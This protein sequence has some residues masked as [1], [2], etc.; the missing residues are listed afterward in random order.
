MNEAAA[1]PK[2]KTE[3]TSVTMTDGRVVEFAGKRKMLKDTLIDDTKIE[4]SADKSVLQISAGAVKVRLDFRNGQTITYD[5][6]LDLAARFAGHGAEQKLGDNL[7]SKA[8]DPMSEE[9][10][11]LETEALVA[12]LSKGN[13]G[14]GRAEGGGGVAGAAAVVRALMEV[15]GKDATFVKDY[16]QKQLEAYPGLSRAALYKSFEAE[17]L[18]TAPIIAKIKAEKVSKGPKIDAAAM[19]AGMQ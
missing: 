9:D 4:L 6:G 19:L 17:G 16:L 7:A 3:Y 8:D 15:T 12:E 18:P 11:F 2:S 1:A 14:R 13:W 5:L 10:M